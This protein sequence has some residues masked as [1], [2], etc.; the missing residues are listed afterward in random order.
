MNCY[1]VSSILRTNRLHLIMLHQFSLVLNL[2]KNAIP[3]EMKNVHY[4]DRKKKA[5]MNPQ[6]MKTLK[7]SIVHQNS[8]TLFPYLTSLS[9]LSPLNNAMEAPSKAI[10]STAPTRPTPA[11]KSHPFRRLKGSFNSET[12]SSFANQ[13][14]L[15]L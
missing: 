2:Y 13:T 14:T 1:S 15:I 8:K 11:H 7:R 3:R 5:F 12:V 6:L 9:G 4:I 10:A